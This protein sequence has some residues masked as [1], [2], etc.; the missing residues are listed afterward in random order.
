MNFGTN[1]SHSLTPGAGQLWPRS[2]PLTPWKSTGL[3]GRISKP[4]LS[5]GQLQQP[6]PM[7]D[8]DTGGFGEAITVSNCMEN[9]S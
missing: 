3:M 4:F 2:A 6:L 7:S 9:G 5:E 1:L 8:P